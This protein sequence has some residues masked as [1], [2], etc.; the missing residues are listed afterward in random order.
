Q[1]LS[2]VAAKRSQYPI[3]S[4]MT[5][6]FIARAR[7][8]GIAMSRGTAAMLMKRN[9]LAVFA[10]IATVAAAALI[11]SFLVLGKPK[12]SLSAADHS[13]A[14]Q[15]SAAVSA[16]NPQHAQVPDVRMREQFALAR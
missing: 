8:E 11:M 13:P 4:G 15:A 5:Q 14:N 12:T 10:A 1:G 2:M 16:T 9:R 3:P 7:S 6:R